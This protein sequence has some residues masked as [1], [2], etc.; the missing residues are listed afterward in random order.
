MIFDRAI[1]NAINV[2]GIISYLFF[3]LK[4]KVPSLEY[5]AILL[6]NLL[7]HIGFLFKN[8]YIKKYKNNNN[9]I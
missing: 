2:I 6:N 1:K 3:L 8:K 5:F 4:S 7:D 9:E